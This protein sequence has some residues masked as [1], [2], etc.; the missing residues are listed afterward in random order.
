M[1]DPLTL[2]CIDAIKELE[3]VIE[4]LALSH[5]IW[6]FNHYGEKPEQYGL[7]EVDFLKW[8]ITDQQKFEAK[9]NELIEE[10]KTY[11]VRD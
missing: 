9:V 3:Q 7:E 1:K 6:E 11:L 4:V 5:F 2:E 8:R 10:G